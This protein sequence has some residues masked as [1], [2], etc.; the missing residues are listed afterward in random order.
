M[1]THIYIYQKLS[2]EFIEKHEDKADWNLISRYQKLSE[3]FIEK[4]AEEIHWNSISFYQKMS[5]DFIEKHI[6]KIDWKGISRQQA[7]SENFIEQHSDKVDWDCISHFQ[8]LSN[9]F[10]EKH[11]DKITF[12]RK[13]IMF[14]RDIE[15]LNPYEKVTERFLSIFDKN[16]EV[17]WNELLTKYLWENKTDNAWL[18]RDDIY[19]L[20]GCLKN[21]QTKKGKF[22]LL[23][24]CLIFI[25]K[26]Y[27]KL[28][29]KFLESNFKMSLI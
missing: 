28:I 20:I 5:E 27:L 12:Q 11:K 22:L 29:L 17:S 14:S 16:E 3:E 21:N 1:D 7:L 2:E 24:F 6:D 4:H 8:V 26:I 25:I 19:W 10:I 18:Y 23:F 15:P 9:S 13:L